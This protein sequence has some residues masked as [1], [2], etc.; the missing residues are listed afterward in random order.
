[1]AAGPQRSSR[2]LSL[3]YLFA[4]DEVHHHELR[5]PRARERLKR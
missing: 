5:S 3:M 1:L 2:Y 4:I